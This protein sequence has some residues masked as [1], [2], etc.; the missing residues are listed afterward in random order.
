MRN[1]G[2]SLLG[3]LLQKVG[4]ENWLSQGGGAAGSLYGVRIGVCPGVGGLGGLPTA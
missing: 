1:S 4:A 2:K 3:P